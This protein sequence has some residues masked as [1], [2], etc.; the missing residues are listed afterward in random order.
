MAN[1]DIN[2]DKRPPKN[3]RG[4]KRKSKEPSN[5]SPQKELAKSAPTSSSAVK[6]VF[7]GGTVTCVKCLSCEKVSLILSKIPLFYALHL[8]VIPLALSL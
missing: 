5:G 2:T 1:G 6:D 4:R 8:T 7:Q 3:R